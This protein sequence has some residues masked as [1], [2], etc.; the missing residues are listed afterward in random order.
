[1]NSKQMTSPDADPKAVR[2]MHARGN[3][4]ARLEALYEVLA[5]RP[6]FS[7]QIMF[8]IKSTRAGTARL[9][10]REEDGAFIRTSCV[11]KARAHNENIAYGCWGEFAA[12]QELANA[13]MAL[14]QAADYVGLQ[15]VEKW[16]SDRAQRGRTINKGVRRS[17]VRMRLND[18]HTV[19]DELRAIARTYHEQDEWPDVIFDESP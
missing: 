3:L 5:C 6:F 16:F 17:M 18:D 4:A 7:D 9:Y 15:E 12:D 2:L 13:L 8:V 11:A 1:M 14:A 10:L 19:A